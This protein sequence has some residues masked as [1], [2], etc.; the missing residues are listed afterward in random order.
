MKNSDGRKHKKDVKEYLRKE[1]RRRVDGGES[2]S[3]VMRDL[4]LSRSAY[5]KQKQ[6]KEA[7]GIDP[8]NSRKGTGRPSEISE[9]QLNQIRIWINGND[10]R[11][12]GFDFGLWTRAIICE[13]VKKNFGIEI[14]VITAGRWLSKLGITPQK[15]LRRSY[16][17]DEDEI[18]KWKEEDFKKIRSRCKRRKAKIFFMDEAGVRSDDPLGRS[19]GIKGKTPIVKT[20]GQR[21]QVNAISAVAPD[22]SFWYEVYS[23]RFNSERM[24]EMLKRFMKGRG[25]VCL[26][27]D[28]H[29]AHKSNMIKQFVKDCSGRLEIYFLPGYAPELNPDEFVWHEIKQNGTSKRPLNK[30]EAL[31]ERVEQDLSELKG[32]KVKLRNFFKSKHVD[33]IMN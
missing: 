7:D 10:P 6:R 5:Y 1:A 13:L 11:Q 9:K 31:K 17:R 28:G 29:P 4:G 24:V 14:S 15:P 25:N 18:K 26:I 33:Y 21:Q 30:N 8:L 32:N 27:L 16:E 19:W 2:I 12:Y 22:G 20:S 23:G 3:K